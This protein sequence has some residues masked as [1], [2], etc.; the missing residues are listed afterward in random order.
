MGYHIEIRRLNDDNKD[1][2]VKEIALKKDASE[3]NDISNTIEKLYISYNH[4]NLFNEYEIHPR[5]FNIER[6]KDI[7]SEYIKVIDDLRKDRD[8]NNDFIKIYDENDNL[9]EFEEKLEGYELNYYDSYKSTVFVI[10]CTIIF[11]LK[12]CNDDDFWVSD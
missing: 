10:A 12:K 2:T 5:Y 3:L 9:E 11:T 6:V 1:L 7:M 4:R 8:V